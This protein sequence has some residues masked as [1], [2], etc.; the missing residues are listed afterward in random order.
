MDR[1]ALVLLLAVVILGAAAAPGL[2]ALAGRGRRR[3]A[4]RVARKVDLALDPPVGAVVVRR[5]AHRELV[6]SATG[7]A[8]GLATLLAVA[9]LGTAGEP[10]QYDLMWVLVAVLG[11]RA[12]GAAAAA[13][14]GTLGRAP[15]A[16]VRIA[17]ASTPA[18]RDYVPPME[19]VGAWVAAGVAATL[20]LALVVLDATGAVDLGDPPP[21]AFVLAAVAPAAV[22][23]LDEALA[24]RVLARP[25]RAETT[26]ELAWDDAL[27]ARALRDMV[28]VPLTIGVVAPLV[29]LG[30]VGAGL[31][32]GWPANPAVGLVAGLV[33]AVLFGV[34]VVVLVAATVSAAQRPERYFRQRLW[35]GPGPGVRS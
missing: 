19:R 32:G 8:A 27:R 31:E 16:A 13:V 3:L 26:L 30:V 12:L 35:G 21:L 15:R 6:A 4:H 17:R 5:L 22:A 11:G 33:A 10:G 1:H 9:P 34:L 14:Y 24:R 7:T 20:S 23:A 2:T 18:H 28:T 25:Q 29:L